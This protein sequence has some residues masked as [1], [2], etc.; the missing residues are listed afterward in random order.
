MRA[1]TDPAALDRLYERPG[2]V[3]IR[4]SPLGGPVVHLAARQATAA[5]AI[6][7]AQVLEWQVAGRDLLW[8]SPLS[9]L[10]TGKSVRGGIPVCWPWFGPH[11]GD[12]GK[13]Q[14]GFVRTRPWQVVASDGDG[15]RASVT[16]AYDA[17]DDDQALWPSRAKVRVTVTLDDALSLALETVNEGADTFDLTQA[18]HTYFRVGD[19]ASV[20]V[21]GLDGRDYLD[22]PDGYARKRQ[23]G[24]ISI[25]GEVDRIYVGDIGAI[26]LV[27]DALG[28][29]IGIAGTGSRSAVVWNPWV[30]RTAQMGDMGAADAYRQMLCVETANAGDDVVRVRPGASHTLGVRYTLE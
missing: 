24:A 29:Q 12:P 7:G 18:L 11:P 5:V 27:D 2:A 20:Q 9:R 22:K 26:R 17:G 25:T 13:P 3:A 19:I 6:Q 16:L 8:L 28:R 14:H 30:E 1:S 10:G 15:G 23:V 21:L 4:E